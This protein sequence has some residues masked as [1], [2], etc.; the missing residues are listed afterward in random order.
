MFSFIPFLFRNRSSP[1]MHSGQIRIALCWS[2]LAFWITT[3]YNLFLYNIEIVDLFPQQLEGTT[4][5]R[6]HFRNPQLDKRDCT[7]PTMRGLMKVQVKPKPVKHHAIVLEKHATRHRPVKTPSS[8]YAYAFIIGGIHQDRPAY[9][10]FVYD[11]LVSA[12]LL[13]KLGS[14]CD[15][16]VWAQ[17]SANSTLQDLPAED[18][19]MFQA[20]N[21]HVELL[22]KP[23]HDSFAHIVFEKFRLLQMTQYKRVMFLD[24]DAIPLANLDYMF[25]LSDPDNPKEPTLLRPNLIM[26]SRGEPVNAGMF[27]LEP[28][29]GDW[30]FL[31]GIIERKEQSAKDLHLSY[32]HFDRQNGWGHN[33]R[34]EGDLWEGISYNG[35][36]WDYYASHSDQ[37]LLYY[38]ARFFK[39]DVSIV[40]GAKI[41]NWVPDKT[42]GLPKLLTQMLNE[43]LMN[44]SAPA[45][46]AYQHDCDDEKAAPNNVMHHACLVPYR[47]FAHFMGKKNKPWQKRYRPMYLTS[48]DHKGYNGAK[49]I[50][51][52]EL[53]EIN[54]K[55]SM[56][57]DFKAWEASK[58]LKYMK[59]SPLGYMAMF[60]DK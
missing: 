2:L 32:P 21:I 60:K 41:Q 39:Q 26:A 1:M 9:K 6:P 17:L 37:G 35:S 29:E 16:W 23:E 49:R 46:L 7:P 8:P 48:T 44:Y 4:G 54:T 12:N 34:K 5:C 50:W 40:I 14:T 38:W 11:I 55:H 18:K 53:V 27:I 28:K 36:R 56:G 30:E 20:L 33:F 31:Q 3:S 57:I 19:R 52:Q 22:E 58:D 13:R 10:G 43:P 15:I 25:H 42:T 24:A 59:E 45:P 51:F 47:D